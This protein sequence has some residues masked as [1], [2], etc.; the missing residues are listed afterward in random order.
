MDII[1]NILLK[2]DDTC[3]VN[4]DVITVTKNSMLYYIKNLTLELSDKIVKIGFG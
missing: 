3:Y 2:S 1:E 4:Y